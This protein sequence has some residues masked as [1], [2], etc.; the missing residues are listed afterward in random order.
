MYKEKKD[1]GYA[2]LYW[3]K[4]GLKLSVD[5]RICV[6]TWPRGYYKLYMKQVL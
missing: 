2:C 4:S 6:I 1:L 5:S 3:I